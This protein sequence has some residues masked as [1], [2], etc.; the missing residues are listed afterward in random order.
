METIKIC[1]IVIPT[2]YVLND[3]AQCT[4]R[5][6]M[7]KYKWIEE[8]IHKSFLGEDRPDNCLC[9]TKPVSEC[10][11]INKDSVTLILAHY[12]PNNKK[13][14]LTNYSRCFK[15]LVDGLTGSSYFTDDNYTNLPCVIFIGGNE[16]NWRNPAF[17]I[18]NDSLPV[19]DYI[20]TIGNVEERMQTTK[21]NKIDNY[22][23]FQIFVLKD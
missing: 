7:G 15:A 11:F 13:F 4:Y 1:E 17:G 22:D 8:Q 14:D 5:Y 20:R 12:K 23:L 2:P 3:N 16:S 9:W 19:K 18:V 10:D 21:Y 6:N